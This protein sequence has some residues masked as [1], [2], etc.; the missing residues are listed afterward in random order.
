MAAV[1]SGATSVTLPD[2][3]QILITREF[4]APAQLVYRAWT[5]PELVRRWWSAN[6]GE[7]TVCEI[8]LRVGGRWRYAMTAHDGFEVAFSGEYREIVAGQRLVT[9]EVFEQMPDAVAV[10]TTTFADLGGRTRVAILVQHGSQAS[11]DHH[12]EAGMEDGLNDALD[13]IQDVALAGVTITR[14]FAAPPEQVFRAWTEARQFGRWFGTAATTVDDVAMDVR[15]GGTWAARM[16]LEDGSRIDWHGRYVDVLAPSL[17]VL[18]ISDRPGPEYDVV[19]VQLAEAD[20]GTCMM[21]SQIGGHQDA[22][23]YARVEHG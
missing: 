18:T 15:P 19:T 21:F 17:L 3:K 4:D 1:R 23:G 2:A 7:M 10:T 9:T 12:L 22:D 5:T 20:G 13:L 6:R 8:D 16:T 14:H 11:R